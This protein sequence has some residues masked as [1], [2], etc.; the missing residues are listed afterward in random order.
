M[1]D[2][3]NGIYNST[4]W[5]EG[6][7]KSPLLGFGFVIQAITVLTGPTAVKGGDS[8]YN[9][10]HTRKNAKVILDVSEEELPAVRCN[11]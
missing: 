10:Q 7:D 4:N 9:D 3:V 11:Q 6:F 1:I 5:N 2:R 8:H